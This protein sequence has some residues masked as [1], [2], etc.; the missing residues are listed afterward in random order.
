MRM[1]RLRFIRNTLIG[2]SLLEDLGHFLDTYQFRVVENRIAL[3]KP[4]PPDGDV[5]YPLP[6]FQ[7]GFTDTIST[8]VESGLFK[9]GCLCRSCYQDDRQD[10]EYRRR[11]QSGS[12]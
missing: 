5:L 6:P 11:S 7:G 10:E 4:S 8:Y 1:R 2:S 3:L 12:S 9:I